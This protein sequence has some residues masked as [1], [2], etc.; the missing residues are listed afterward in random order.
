[1]CVK[2]VHGEG[3][4][5]FIR[6]L[7]EKKELIEREGVPGFSSAILRLNSMQG[8]ELWEYQNYIKI[9]LKEIPQTAAGSEN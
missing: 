6:R 1:V 3:G 2:G 7:L 8:I 9:W 4:R 5:L